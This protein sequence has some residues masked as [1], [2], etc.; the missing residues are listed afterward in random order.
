MRFK[1]TL[2]HVVRIMKRG[3]YQFRKRAYSTACLA[4]FR[5]MNRSKEIK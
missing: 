5:K 2:G 4:N 3:A 1:A